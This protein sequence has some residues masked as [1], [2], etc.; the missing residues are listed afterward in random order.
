MGE[1]IMTTDWKKV[2]AEAWSAPNWR[3]AG[4]Q[5]QH[6]RAGRPLIVEIE[7][8]HLKLLRTL[9]GEIS[10][11][12]A[13]AEINDPRNRTTPQVTVEAIVFS[14]QER[15]IGALKDPSNIERLSR[16]GKAAKNEI[17]RRI[18]K[19]GLKS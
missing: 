3:E 2:A 15:G 12:R 10:L 4:A 18:E 5:Y 16:C 13:W 17:N 6:A 7:P 14:V 1:V 19:L 11:E 8:E 9:M